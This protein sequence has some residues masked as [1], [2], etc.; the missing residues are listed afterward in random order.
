MQ[1]ER[2]FI[3]SWNGR[4]GVGIHSVKHIEN[5]QMGIK[6]VGQHSETDNTGVGLERFDS[7][8]WAGRAVVKNKESV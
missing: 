5:G 2:N 7:T 8:D 4:Q 1:W 3:Q 6:N